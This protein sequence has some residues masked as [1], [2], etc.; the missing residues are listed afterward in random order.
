M[1]HVPNV[2]ITLYYQKIKELA[3]S[4]HVNQGTKYYKMDLV[5][6]VILILF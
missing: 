5:S 3:F 6:H 4:H 2:R 1:E